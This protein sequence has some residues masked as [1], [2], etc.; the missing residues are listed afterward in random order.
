M[1]NDYEHKQK[2]FYL[3]KEEAITNE[4]ETDEKIFKKMPFY[5]NKSLDWAYNIIKNSEI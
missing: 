1:I 5:L 4:E 3:T 2:F